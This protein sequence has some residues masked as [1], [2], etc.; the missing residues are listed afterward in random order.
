MTAAQPKKPDELRMSA[1]DFDR[2]M[3]QALQVAPEEIKKSKRV[4][5]AKRPKKKPAASK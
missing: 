5:K 2:I 1:A 4:A 3:V